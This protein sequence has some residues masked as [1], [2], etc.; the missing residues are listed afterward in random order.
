MYVHVCIY[1]IIYLAVYLCI[2]ILNLIKIVAIFGYLIVWQ[3]RLNLMSSLACL[4]IMFKTSFWDQNLSISQL[5]FSC[6]VASF[7]I[8]LFTWECRYSRIYSDYRSGQNTAN[9]YFCDFR[10]CPRMDFIGLA[11]LLLFLEWITGS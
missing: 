9:L 5:W 8:A 11:W 3:I 10:K 2:Y 6:I 4:I 1:V 7:R